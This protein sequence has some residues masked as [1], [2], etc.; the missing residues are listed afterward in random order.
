MAKIEYG[1]KERELAQ[2]IRDMLPTIG[3]FVNG[4]AR[5][6]TSYNMIDIESPKRNIHLSIY[7]IDHIE[8]SRGRLASEQYIEIHTRY[9]SR[10]IIWE[11]GR[12][13]T[14]LV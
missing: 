13:R 4:R 9:M 10:V 6:G 14:H 2:R 8:L 5:L 1:E 12:I 3:K 7:N 11:S